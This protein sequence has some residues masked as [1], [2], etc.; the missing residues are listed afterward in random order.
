MGTIIRFEDI[1]AWQKSR[2]LTKDIYV[3]TKSSDFENDFDLIRQMRR[4]TVSVMANIAEGFERKREKQFAHFL[5]ISMGSFAELKSH[6]Y[7]CLDLKCITKVAFKKFEDQIEEIGK[8]INSLR[9][10][11]KE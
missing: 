6:L 11:L 7:I 9:K 1:I 4:C 8:M 2:L 3:A 10:Y 5:D